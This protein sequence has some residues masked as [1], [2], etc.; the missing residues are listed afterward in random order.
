MAAQYFVDKLLKFFEKTKFHIDSAK[1]VL[2][3]I[4]LEATRPGGTIL[5]TKISMIDVKWY[6][7]RCRQ[8]NYKTLSDFTRY[9]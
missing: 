8:R 5:K 1:S 9:T 4:A 3:W 6:K 7:K 2:E